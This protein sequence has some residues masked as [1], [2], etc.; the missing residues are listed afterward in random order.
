VLAAVTFAA[1]ASAATIPGQYIVVLKDGVS[2]PTSASD[3]AKK[4]AQVT[5]NYR[6]ALNGYAAK[7]SD[8]ALTA[9]R[10]DRKMGRRLPRRG[11]QAPDL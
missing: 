8:S 3:A 4:G 1:S 11:R 6:H 7:L 9:I 10:A 2:E 5:Q